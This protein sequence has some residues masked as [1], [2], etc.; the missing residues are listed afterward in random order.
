MAFIGQYGTCRSNYVVLAW[1]PNA[2]KALI[3]RWS[4][5]AVFFVNNL[6]IECNSHFLIIYKWKILPSS[7]CCCWQPLPEQSPG[8]RSGQ[9][10]SHYSLLFLVLK[11][12]GNDKLFLIQSKH[13]KSAHT[14]PQTSACQRPHNLTSLKTFKGKRQRCKQIQNSQQNGRMSGRLIFCTQENVCDNLC[15]FFHKFMWHKQ[16]LKKLLE[17]REISYFNQGNTFH[18]KGKRRNI[19]VIAIKERQ[20]YFI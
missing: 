4:E 19:Y 7:A 16:L 17:W 9:S 13:T 8:T 1:T 11:S 2:R 5:P 10:T 6:C 18:D 15:S 14:I 12:Q 20:C 3:W